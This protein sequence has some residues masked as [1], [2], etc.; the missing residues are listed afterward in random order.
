MT[1]PPVAIVTGAGS[2]IGRNVCQLLAMARCKIALVGRNENTLE[3]TANLLAAEIANP[4]ET[5][6]IPADVSDHAQAAGVVDMTIERWGRV[7][8][9]INNAAVAGLVGLHEIDE[10]AL[11]QF[12][13]INTFGPLHLT[14]RCWP[15][16]VKHNAGCVVNVSSV[17]AFSPFPGLGV[18]GMSKAA[19]DGLTR[20]IQTE[21]QNHGITA[22]SV[23]PG[24]VET[25]MLRGVISKK[26][27][28][29]EQTLDPM[30]VAQLI[31]DCALGKRLDDAG[32]VI[33]LSNR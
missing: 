15:S 30:E 28:P 12:F 14:R 22:Y 33:Q 16:F 31:V 6:I 13:A 1:I 2:G 7:N 21:G 27:L 3:E 29:T 18:Y 23:A 26:D 4:P 5:L 24:A 9:L 25:A 20:A 32:G 11:Y 8:I 17:A 19:L 10:D